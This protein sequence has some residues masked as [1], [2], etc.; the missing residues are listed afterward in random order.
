MAGHCARIRHSRRTVSAARHPTRQYLLDRVPGRFGHILPPGWHGPADVSAGELLGVPARIL[1]HSMV[2]S[3]LRI[4]VAQAGPPAR[5]KRGVVLEV[6][7]GRRP[8]A[9]RPG[10]GRVPDFG[11]VPEHHSGVVSP[12]LVPVITFPAWQRLDT[13]EHLAVPGGQPPGAGSGRCEGKPGLAGRIRATGRAVATGFSPFHRP[14]A[15]V[16]DGVPVPVGDG[17]VPG[18]AGVAG[19][20]GGQLAGQIRVSQT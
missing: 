15:A 1:F 4:S 6:G 8:S 13:D 19:R 18:G 12:S 11:K 10:A 2:G 17:D 5:L 16:R 14:G 3:A 20:G 9:S 7:P